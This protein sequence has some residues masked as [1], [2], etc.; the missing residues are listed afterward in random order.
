VKWLVDEKAKH[1]KF[2]HFKFS[3]ESNIHFVASSLNF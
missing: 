3:F 1:S 2:S